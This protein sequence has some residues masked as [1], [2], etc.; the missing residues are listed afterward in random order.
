MSE[1]RRPLTSS[2]Y[3][4]TVFMSAFL[5][6]QVQP[7]ISKFI[8]PWFGGSPAVWTTC[9]L[10]FQVVLF[11]GYVYS[12]VVV[13]N[14]SPKSQTVLHVVLLIAATSLLPIIP[15][16]A[17][18]PTGAGDPSGRI[19]LL[20]A[21]TVGLPYFVLSTTGPLLQGWYFR[22]LP[23]SSPYR[24][25][26]LSNIGSLLA[27]ISYPFAVEP[28]FAT[29]NQAL[30]WSWTFYVFAGCCAACAVL[31]V[32]QTAGESVVKAEP[33]LEEDPSIAAGVLNS[34]S[35]DEAVQP[36]LDEVVNQPAKKFAAASIVATDQSVKLAPG[37][38]Q[39]FFWFAL[40]AAPSVMLLA[41][42]NQVCTDIA[43]VPFLW[44][45]PLSLYLM[46]FILCFDS[47]RWYSRRWYSVLLAL[48]VG[49]TLF[50]LW[51]NA[52]GWRLAR[53]IVLQASIYFGLMFCSCMVC[54]GE[55]VRLK[56]DP[57]YLTTFYLS[58][59][60]GGA[61]GGLLVGLVAPQVFKT[62]FE[63]HVGIVVTC[64]LLILV[65]SRDAELATV[66]RRS[67][68]VTGFLLAV[69]GVLGW[70]LN[71]QAERVTRDAQSIERNFYGVVRVD[72]F[73]N[74]V[75]LK[76][77]NIRHGHQFLDSERRHLPTTYYGHQSGAGIA[78]AQ[79]KANSPKRVGVIGL[80]AGTLAVY[81]KPGDYYRMYEINPAVIRLAGEYFTY[82]SECKGKTETIVGDARIML[83]NEEPQNFDVLVLDAFSGDAVP[84]HLLTK[85]CCEI[86]LKH[87][88]KDGILA[89]HITNRHVD[90]KPICKGLAS[91]FNL[92]C[93]GMYST[94]DQDLGTQ[95]TLWVL[96][97]PQ[98]KSLAALEFRDARQVDMSG[99][100]ILWTDTWSNLLSVM[101]SAGNV[102]FLDK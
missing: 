82:L 25:Y 28:N 101:S 52:L 45:L 19:I 5:L 72:R 33:A 30:V 3:L 53:S 10:F 61:L 15:D 21:V 60:A 91:E 27:L 64:V 39:L 68:G 100:E 22:T 6:F 54:H 79:H 49:A 41:T 24:L 32:V 76:H 94:R 51:D 23:G 71:A 40:A 57:K 36:T 67:W 31:M 35:V 43:V 4:L 86:Y 99:Q 75:T 88:A 29:E 78:L 47:D 9:M 58:I 13:K 96:L 87:L 63:F 1:N 7:L 17:W 38:G 59:S 66:R 81:A 93:I 74:S 65:I 97:S 92:A 16:S 50:L 46:S 37:I 56:P 90:L 102:R 73:T 77:G 20:L 12:H 80:G 85:E 55:L 18:K 11:A 48:F 98:Q 44:V 83:E 34:E 26:S 14:L 42:T 95:D 2:I 84:T 70:S 89:F 69:V 62:H 8:L